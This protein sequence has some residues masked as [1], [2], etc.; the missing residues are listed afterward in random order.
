MQ[1]PKNTSRQ[2]WSWVGANCP[3]P[4]TKGVDVSFC[5]RHH[6]ATLETK[7]TNM[8]KTSAEITANRARLRTAHFAFWICGPEL[9]LRENGKSSR[10]F[11]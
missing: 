7:K 1:W 5:G 4:V 11:H 3:M 2:C 10:G 9:V 8:K 6:A